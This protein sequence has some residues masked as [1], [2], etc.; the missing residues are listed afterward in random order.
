MLRLLIEGD[1][2]GAVLAAAKL[3]LRGLDLGV[4]APPL[5]GVL[6]RRGGG[7]G[8]AVD[9]RG[10]RRRPLLCCDCAAAPYF[11]LI[12]EGGASRGSTRRRVA[13]G[14]LSSPQLAS[15]KLRRARGPKTNPPLTTTTKTRV[16][17]ARAQFRTQID[18][19]SVPSTPNSAVRLVR[20]HRQETRRALDAL[21]VQ[22]TLLAAKRGMTL[23]PSSTPLGPPEN[24]LCSAP[25]R[26]AHKSAQ[27]PLGP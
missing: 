23:C 1:P 3:E 11:A 26:R 2:V 16:R 12:R 9:L 6:G 8:D 4:G 22:I 14:G 15:A 7:G 19:I 20:T 18:H 21:P 10:T 13:P 24:T 25:P 5:V 17:G 27:L